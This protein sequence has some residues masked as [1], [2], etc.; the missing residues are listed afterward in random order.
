MNDRTT[1]S[2]SADNAAT[3]N[4]FWPTL[5]CAIAL[6]LVVGLFMAG[7]RLKGESNSY[8]LL[9]LAF[10][11]FIGYFGAITTGLLWL[12]LFALSRLFQ[13][14]GQRSSWLLLIPAMF[15]FVVASMP[16]GNALAKKS[17]AARLQQ[18]VLTAL[19]IQAGG[20]QTWSG[21]DPHL[22]AVSGEVIGWL[23]E[24]KSAAPEKLAEIAAVF[25]ENVHIATRIARQPGCSS[26]LLGILWGRVHFWRQK[27]DLRTFE[28]A[29]VGNPACVDALHWRVL[30]E[31][32]YSD[33]R[34]L[35]LARKSASI[36]G[37][38][39]EYLRVSTESSD[40]FT[41]A[42]FAKDLRLPVTLMARLAEDE[43]AIVRAAL[44]TNPN[45]PAKQL[46]KL[47]EDPE[48]RVR[49]SV[50][51]RPET[52]PEWRRTFFLEAANSK[53]SDLRWAAVGDD[54]E[55]SDST[56]TKLSD[57]ESWGIRLTVAQ[58]RRTPRAV[59]EKLARDANAE[60]RTT[61]QRR[62]Q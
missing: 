50:A 17:A 42:R 61:A 58:H 2:A 43:S 44:A 39:E 14:S 47:A 59:L 24:N 55:A 6:G 8:G 35:I 48:L 33:T 29:I 31:T 27:E 20:G 38:F 3:K 30:R 28:A 18:Q 54:P 22:P 45:L 16:A 62:L 60:I 49:L 52:P 15:A 12:P 57:D 11:V 13:P 32:P 21:I 51:L 56:L 5:F 1:N 37:L 19:Q 40:H 23:E 4:L 41:R 34:D 10:V 46:E 9:P 53:Y 25:S 36:P 26:H 7:Y